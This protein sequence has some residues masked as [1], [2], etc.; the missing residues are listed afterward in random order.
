MSYFLTI[1]DKFIVIGSIIL[2]LLLAFNIF[3]LTMIDRLADLPIQIIDHPLEVSNAAYFANIEVI[4]M[5]KDLERIFLVEE[6][7]EVSILID[8]IRVAEGKVYVALDIIAYDILGERGQLLQNDARIIFDDWKVIRTNIIETIRRDERD[9]ALEI[10]R[11]EGAEHA[12]V[13]ER[14]LVE[15]NQYA[16]KK[17]TGFQNDVIDLES[18]LRNTAIIGM[19]LV[20]ICILIS[21]IWISV[22]VLSSI[23]SLSVQLGEIVESGELKEVYLDGNDELVEL[24]AVFNDLIVSLDRQIWL[25]EGNKRLYNILNNTGEV[26]EVVDQ[27]INE[28]KEY[29]D[30]ISIAYYELEKNKLIM[31]NVVNRLSFMA[32]HYAYG[33]GIIGESFKS[34]EMKILDYGQLTNNN[35]GDLPY[36][37]IVASPVM[38][39]EDGYGGLMFVYG[40]SIP[41]QAYEYLHN[42]LIDFSLYINSTTQRQQID[43][44][45]M[46][47]VK[48]M[49]S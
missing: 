45:F 11:N 2:V 42:A 4:R 12:D 8:K 22:S 34:R 23:H 41:A 20:I 43:E 17:A 27:F 48:K 37:L 38:N 32:G 9:K 7:Y 28:M 44:L 36:Q 35:F 6:D 14:K 3:L 47:S 49:R 16:R 10:L 15:L 39:G 40:S 18:N 25:K 46:E 19:V 31:K 24:S 1:R 33:E 13:L 21:I 5:Q 30:M 29:S 26:D